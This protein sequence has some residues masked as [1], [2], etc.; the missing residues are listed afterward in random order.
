MAEAKG[1]AVFLAG[2]QSLI[3][4][5]KMGLRAPDLLI[6]IADIA[7]L[8]GIR[9][10]GDR[11]WIGAGETYAAIASTALV[12][13]TIPALAHLT[14]AIGDQQV[15]NQ[16]TLGGAIAMNDPAMDCP[17]AALAL[18]ARI[19]TSQ[20]SHT[21]DAFFT[22]MM[23]TARQPDEILT[24]LSF[25]IPRA[26]A[27][28]SFRQRAS[29]YAL[30]GVFVALFDTPQDQVRVVVVGGRDGCFRWAQAEECLTPSLDSVP[31]TT[32][33]TA[34]DITPDPAHMG[35][36]M[37]ASRTYRAHLVRVMLHRAID[38]IRAANAPG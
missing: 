24:G 14:G 32:P 1:D 8:H 16:A 10:D 36:D 35:H 7:A 4:F 30:A 17:A 18:K 13:E 28:A 26:A 3:P 25:A 31:N 19:E 9:R 6:D 15:R 23:S 37:H 22:G 33:N 29:G 27:Y 11:L 12:H 20:K 2:G 34:P 5:M 21:A 38:R